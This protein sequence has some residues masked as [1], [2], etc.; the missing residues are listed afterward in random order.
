[1][2]ITRSIFL[3]ALSILIGM[4]IFVQ[5]ANALSASKGTWSEDTTI[6]PA[7]STGDYG[8]EDYACTDVS[9]EHIHYNT[10]TDTSSTKY[11]LAIH[12]FAIVFD[13]DFI[14]NVQTDSDFLCSDGDDTYKDCS[15]DKV[16]DLNSV[17]YSVSGGH[18]KGVSV[19]YQTLNWISGSPKGL[20]WRYGLESSDSGELP[21]LASGGRKTEGI[22]FYLEDYNSPHTVSTSS[23]T[24]VESFYVKAGKDASKTS[25]WNHMYTS[26][27]SPKS[28][29]V[30]PDGD[31][32]YW[33][34]LNGTEVSNFEACPAGCAD[35]NITPDQSALSVSDVF[36][37]LPI[38]VTATDVEGKDIT[39]DSTFMY[40]AYKYGSDPSSGSHDADGYFQSRLWG[41]DR[42]TTKSSLTYFKTEPG[43]QIRVYVSDYD[44]ESYE[45]TCDE[46]I[47]LPYCTDLSIT[48]PTAWSLNVQYGDTYTNN[49]EIEAEAS[50]GEPWPFK[51]KYE[52][53]DSGS[54]FDGNS[55]PYSTLDWIIDSYVSTQSGKVSVGLN[56]HNSDL[57]NDDVAGLCSDS[58]PYLLLP[59]T[60]FP[61]CDYLDIII[62]NV[63][64][65][66]SA[67]MTAGN[68]LI[69]WESFMTDGSAATGPWLVLSS[70]PTGQFRLTPGGPIAGT[71]TATV[72]VSTVY[73]TGTP[74]DSI[75]VWDAKPSYS[76]ACRDTITSKTGTTTAPIC[77]DLSLGDPYIINDDGSHTTL[78]LDDTADITSLYEENVVC[79]DYSIGVSDT[80]F[81]GTLLAEARSSSAVSGNLSLTVNE[82]GYNMTGNPI[83]VGVSGYA[84]YSGTVCWE[85]YEPGDTISIGILGSE[86]TCSAEETLPTV[87]ETYP[88]CVDLQMTPDSYSLSASDASAGQI[89][90]N[91]N[92]N[93][94]D[95]S[96]TG[97]LIVSKNGSGVL[98]Y[99]DGS[100]SGFSD[101]HLEIPVNYS[102]SAI[103][104]YYTGGVAGDLVTAY[105]DGEAPICSD[106]FSLSKPTTPPGG[107][108]PG[109][110]HTPPGPSDEDHNICEDIGFTD[111]SFLIGG[112]CEDIE[113][114]VCNDA[115]FTQTVE[116][117]YEDQN[118]DDGLFTV[119]GEE[120]EGCETI[121]F[122]AGE[123][124][125]LVY[126]EVCEGALIEV[127]DQGRL[128]D[129]L[130]VE[131][132]E[133]QELGTFNKYIFT[134]NFSAEKNPYSDEGVFFAHDEDRAFY[135]LEYDPAG[136][137]DQIIFTD[138]MWGEDLDSDYGGT[139]HLAESYSELTSGKVYGNS[140]NYSSIVNFGFGSDHEY[141]TDEIAG[142]LNMSA[143]DYRTFVPYIK[144]DS[145]TE[146]VLIDACEYDETSG[147]LTTETVCY[148]PNITPET[149]GEVR[150]EN[151]G[152]VEDDYGSGA[153]IRIRY[154]GVVDSGLNCSDS[155]DDC[156]TEEFQ[157]NAQV[158]VY[159]DVAL[160][161]DA[162][163]VV[164]CSYLLTQNAG[165]VYLEIGLRGGSDLSCI[166]VDEDTNYSGYANTDALVI[167][168]D[169]SS[170][171][172]TSDT[173]STDLT[174]ATYSA[175]TV[176]VCDGDYDN[177]L[178]GNLSSYVCEIVNSVSDLWKKSTV[179][180]TTESRVMTATRNV[181][182]NQT[183]GYGSSPV[184]DWNGLVSTLSNNNNPDN[185]ILYF[186]GSMGSALNLGKLEVSE[187]AWT[188]IVENAD[189]K[190]GGNISYK[191]VTGAGD[192]KNLPSVA[193]VVLGGNIYVED[194]AY[195]L[196]GVYYTD[197]KF[198]GDLRSPVN[199]ELT[200][201]GS[202][203]GNVQDL[204][205]KAKYVA[206]PTSSGGGLVI[207]YDSR[208][209]LNT[210]PGLSEYVD[211]R[212]KEGT[213]Q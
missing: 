32:I 119:D 114:E 122:T 24:K 63:E 172:S 66:P 74:G 171:T 41:N 144:F 196:V 68:L 176:S 75:T 199:G 51:V 127:S 133:Q 200:V 153:V 130:T 20:V 49:I 170:E 113:T 147:E 46:I 30:D 76:L 136:P 36:S 187:G 102:N 92:V 11:K 84:S 137:E 6:V 163:L 97:K 140:Y 179:E 8:E 106:N 71:G 190:L 53:T 128:C 45:G 80:S 184:S 70:N 101:G 22:S 48:D 135:T 167:L 164:L 90:I 4:L 189:L 91:I 33:W 178:I 195:S 59:T 82:M 185:H 118:G 62:P 204:L 89:Q 110:G 15:F 177:S 207:R 88:Y 123:C 117:C 42:E 69:S 205:D 19:T 50:T 121:K 7:V 202:F 38:S 191:T 9:H 61:T 5:G 98:T 182:T 143:S 197:Q 112:D 208:I 107:G 3:P 152:S 103:E 16:T 28:S 157:N 111:D 17:I 35:L 166:Y 73:Y 86:A 64:P 93:G 94:S 134:F 165:D 95:S 211:I 125:N 85:N 2:K 14:D 203:Y 194:S 212:S 109:G 168:D 129:D 192:Y 169:G 181:S 77:E 100:A 18:W 155:S 108:P 57:Q 132:V 96:W 52:S 12:A 159:D 175:S 120:Y 209:L 104:V 58:F 126:E 13:D 116:I 79:W 213:N 65:I 26:S 160:E 198:D 47:T 87:T 55:S 206:P 162:R 43:D 81:S 37:N 29:Q 105:I 156:L 138:D 145:N 56:D 188:V 115:D 149:D 78:D 154:V 161:A 83:A 148:D 44:G 54:T 146:S 34:G 186:D 173:G 99:G 151:A 27:V 141:Y 174:V 180:S 72:A 31:Y 21:R 25:N 193:F 60:T 23:W 158:E 150:I 139:V 67:D 201:D 1:M 142:K 210:P 124:A 40:E 183:V 10:S 131:Q 39:A